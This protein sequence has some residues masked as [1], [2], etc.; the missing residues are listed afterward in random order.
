MR[1]P[2]WTNPR[3]EAGPEFPEKGLVEMVEM[4]EMEMVEMI[5]VECPWMLNV[6]R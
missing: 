5:N 6:E 2:G 4:V 3:G 1:P